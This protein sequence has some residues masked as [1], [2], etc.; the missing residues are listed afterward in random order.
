M[1]LFNLCFMRFITI[2]NH[3]IIHL[4]QLL[5]TTRILYRISIQPHL[6]NHIKTLYLTYHL[7]FFLQNIIIYINY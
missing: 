1:S 2:V 4:N 7:V 6:I 3:V 5:I